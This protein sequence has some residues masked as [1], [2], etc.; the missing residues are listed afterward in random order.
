M[1]TIHEKIDN[2][3]YVDFVLEPKDVNKLLEK[4]LEPTQVILNDQIFNI[5]IRPATQREL[6]EDDE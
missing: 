2:E 5:W 6:D 1:R 4:T 3:T